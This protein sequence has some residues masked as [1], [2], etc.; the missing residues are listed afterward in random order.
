MKTLTA[1]A[2]LTLGLAMSGLADDFTLPVVTG[3]QINLS[4]L[5]DGKKG[6]V[7]VFWSGVCSHCIRYD[8]YFN[9][10][11][12]CHPELALAVVASRVGETPGRHRDVLSAVDR[13]WGCINTVRD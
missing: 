13:G 9:S 12:E 2:T 10:F 4:T 1:V 6:A 7:A 3:G 11:A 5:L 8:G